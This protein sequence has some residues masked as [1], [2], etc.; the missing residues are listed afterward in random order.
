MATTAPLVSQPTVSTPVRTAHIERRGIGDWL[1]TPDHKK[2]G[3]MY[4]VST[5]IFF[6]LGGLAALIVRTQ[7]ALPERQLLSGELYNQV[8]TVH[9]SIMIFLFVIPFGIG[10]LGN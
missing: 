1:T 2:I 6:L 7:L 10:G 8:F 3:I 5:L 9:A 4:L